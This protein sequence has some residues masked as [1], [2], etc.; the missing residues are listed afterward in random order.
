MKGMFKGRSIV[1]K[2]IVLSFLFFAKL[3]ILAHAI[4]PHHHHNGL[5]FTIIAAHHEHDCNSHNDHQRCKDA[6]SDGKCDYTHCNEDFE[7]CVLTMMFVKSCNCR[8]TFLLHHCSFDALPFVFTLLAD[9]SA[10][11]I[12]DDVGLPFRQNPLLPSYLSEYISQSLGLR[13]PPVC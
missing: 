2:S 13:A 11:Q 4:V 8:Q 3:M 7:N 5:I 6:Q 1:R 10:P 9:Y 12:D